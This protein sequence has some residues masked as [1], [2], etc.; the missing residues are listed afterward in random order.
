[1]PGT[2]RVDASVTLAAEVL[3]LIRALYAI[4]AEIAIAM[5]LIQTAK[6]NGVDPMAWL[7]DMLER[8]VS[9]RTQAQELHPCYPGTDH[10]HPS[11]LAALAA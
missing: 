1:M 11:T 3:V 8:I 2:G 10:D 6:L 4:E 5:T 9:G 7:A